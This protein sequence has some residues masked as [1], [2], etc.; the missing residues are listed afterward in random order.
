MTEM[1]FSCMFKPSLDVSCLI[2]EW[3]IANSE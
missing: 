2:G 3:R 1:S